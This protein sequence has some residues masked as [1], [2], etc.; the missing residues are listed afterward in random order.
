MDFKKDAI[1]ILKTV[2][3]SAYDGIVII[4]KNAIINPATYIPIERNWLDNIALIITSICP[5]EPYTKCNAIPYSIK[6]PI[7]IATQ[8]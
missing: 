2:I 8:I 6:N 3:D 4:D 5:K 1:E 7:V